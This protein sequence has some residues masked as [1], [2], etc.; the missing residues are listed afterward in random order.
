LTNHTAYNG[1]NPER[2]RDF[3][4]GLKPAPGTYHITYDLLDPRAKRPTQPPKLEECIGGF[5]FDATTVIDVDEDDGI[6][7]E[8]D[9]ARLSQYPHVVFH[10]IYD[11]PWSPQRE[12]HIERLSQTHYAHK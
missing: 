11:A 6:H 9:A 5:V 4:R 3:W 7:V 10:L 1:N 2:H 12:A 8:T